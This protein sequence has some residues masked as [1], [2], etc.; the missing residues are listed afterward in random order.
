LARGGLSD[1]IS[2]QAKDDQ[3]MTLKRK[4][5]TGIKVKFKNKI[6]D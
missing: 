6:K 3:K 4:P 5:I 2:V 1:T